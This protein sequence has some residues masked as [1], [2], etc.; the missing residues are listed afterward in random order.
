MLNLEKIGKKIST[1]R[2]ELK[3][4]QNELAEMLYVTH[5]AVSKWEN[6]KSIP[7][8]DMIYE[9]TKILHIS[10][11]YLLEDSDISINDYETKF[12]QYPRASVIK[13]FLELDDLDNEID[14]IFYLLTRPERKMI[15]DLII[16]CKTELSV[17]S[18]WHMLSSKERIYLL[19]IIL[20]CKFDYDLNK[21][22]HQLNDTELRITFNHKD[23]GDYPYPLTLNKGVIL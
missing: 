8:I 18:L 13:K 22:I 17:E 1:K 20:T 10:I 6:G 16:N 2:K 5:Q 11:D 4:T 19:T 7:T 21:I 3:I 12:K 15:L 14:K 9:L 23:K